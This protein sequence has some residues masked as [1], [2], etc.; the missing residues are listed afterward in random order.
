[1]I[2]YA[3]IWPTI[4]GTINGIITIDKRYLDTADTLQLKGLKRIT[5]VILPAAMPSILS[6]YIVSLRG[7]FTI[8]VFA[9]MYGTKYG[10]GHF[11]KKFADYGI[12][13]NVW[14]GF[15]FM[16]IILVII[17]RIFEGI[18]SYLLKWTIE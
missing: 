2:V 14:S 8:L 10:M 7:S 18:K 6:G 5:K 13:N 3:T 12:Y 16:V 1:M 15:V 9:E 4:F 11:V 17:L